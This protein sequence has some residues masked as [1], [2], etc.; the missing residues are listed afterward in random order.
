M[1]MNPDSTLG[2]G[3]LDDAVIPATT[4]KNCSCAIH[5]NAKWGTRRQVMM[6]QRNRQSVCQNR[7][8]AREKVDCGNSSSGGLDNDNA[9]IW[10]RR[11]TEWIHQA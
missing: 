9:P 5:N 6:I 8:F 2:E 1:S 11:Y 10:Q 3:D 4:N 7:A